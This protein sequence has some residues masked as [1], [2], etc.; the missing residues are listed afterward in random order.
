MGRRN[1]LAGLA[2]LGALGMILNKRDASEAPD[3]RGGAEDERPA[4]TGMGE[5][6]QLLS[7]RNED[8]SNEG[9]TPPRN[10]VV[11]R[12][13]VR[14]PNPVSAKKVLDQV[15]VGNRRGPSIAEARSMGPQPSSTIPTPQQRYLDAIQEANSAEGRAQRQAQAEAQALTPVRPEEFIGSAPAVG[16]K[17]VAAMAKNLAG[18][19]K[20]TV[21]AAKQAWE[22]ARMS[23]RLTP[24]RPAA[25]QTAQQTGREAVTNPLEWAMGP[26]N[27][28]LAD[29]FL[30]EA[31]TAGGAILY[32]RGGQTKKSTKSFS[33]KPTKTSASSRGDG[34]AMRGKTRG[35]MR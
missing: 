5:A 18:N 30:T 14:K 28:S 23:D 22:R 24:A 1:D 20:P 19:A 34:I 16:I 32:K 7:D 15:S 29:K 21:S 10:L 4:P 3:M 6:T 13:P 17:G 35:I 27:S 2:A 26:K 8:Y 11:D 33:N 12:T 9:R 31:D 25:G